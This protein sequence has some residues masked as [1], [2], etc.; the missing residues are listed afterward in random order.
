MSKHD[1][2]REIE[3][4]EEVV[5]QY[6]EQMGNVP[7]E[8]EY[9]DWENEG[10]AVPP[11]EQ[12]DW[13]AR[14]KAADDRYDKN[15]ADWRTCDTQTEANAVA[16]PMVIAFDFVL[17]RLRT[18]AIRKGKDYGTAGDTT[19]NL[20]ASE[21]FG[22]PAW[23]GCMSRGND[24]MTRLKAFVKN[25]RLHNEPVDDALEDLA[26]YTIWAIVFRNEE[27]YPPGKVT[28]F[29]WRRVTEYER[30]EDNG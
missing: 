27:T 8:P 11:P 4:H 7:V 1:I 19:A 3:A 6:D 5:A 23:V 22:I 15:D 25:G 16:D 26:V 17:E 21:D 10:G 24:K 29:N 18:L 13:D 30:V 9:A 2:E 20:R 14:V 28:R 12:K